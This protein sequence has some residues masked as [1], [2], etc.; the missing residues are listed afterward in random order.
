M[1]PINCYTSIHKLLKSDILDNLGN[2]IV[3]IRKFFFF[4]KIILKNEEWKIMNVECKITNKKNEKCKINKECTEEHLFIV[5]SLLLLKV[6]QILWKKKNFYC[7][8]D[9][10]ED[11]PNLVKNNFET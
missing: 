6:F 5:L 10:T 4:V 2:F 3:Y 11:E 7:V 9:S 1:E 8:H